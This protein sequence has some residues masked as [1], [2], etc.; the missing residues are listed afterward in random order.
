MATIVDCPSCE[1]KLRVPEDL[2]GTR[3]KCPTCGGTFN[4]TA[5]ERAEVTPSA[6]S[7]ASGVTLSRPPDSAASAVPPAGA[8]GAPPLDGG[9][10]PAAPP[11]APPEE[12]DDRP[13]EQPRALRRDWEPHR[14]TLVMTLGIVGLVMGACGGLAVI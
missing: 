2:L 9:T 14:G 12:D 10:A 1:R 4:A 3:V 5:S 6:A 8:D 7:S 13:W 11:P